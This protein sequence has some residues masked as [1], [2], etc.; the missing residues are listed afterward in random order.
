MLGAG[1][2]LIS[3]GSG[4]IGLS[5]GTAGPSSTGDQDAANRN[6]QNVFFGGASRQQIPTW[7]IVAGVGLAALILLRGKK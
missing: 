7:A 4:G 3:G 1:A 6:S 5:G 2:A